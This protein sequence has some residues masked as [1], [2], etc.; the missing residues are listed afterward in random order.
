MM[1][2]ILWGR[3]CYAGTAFEIVSYSPNSKGHN[4]SKFC[5]SERHNYYEV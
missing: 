1:V 4:N 2:V 5:I 3:A